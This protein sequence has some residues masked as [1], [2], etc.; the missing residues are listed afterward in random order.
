MAVGVRK[1]S[2]LLTVWEAH[3]EAV[4]LPIQF[5]LLKIGKATDVKHYALKSR[6]TDTL[7]FILAQRRGVRRKGTTKKRQWD[8]CLY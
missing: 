3:A 6:L 2:V 1:S 7:S 4:T 8:D 5:V